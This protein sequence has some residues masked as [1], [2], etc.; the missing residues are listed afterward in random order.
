MQKKEIRTIYRQQRM[1]L[2]L[3]EVARMEDLL[4]IR[5]QQAG[6]PPVSV[7]MGYMAD[8]AR[9]EPDPGNIIRWFSFISPGMLELAPRIH[10]TGCGM[11]AFIFEEGQ[12]VT[13]NA[14]G[15]AE[16]QDTYPVDPL[17]ID[18]VLVP[19]LAFDRQGNRV[20]YGKGYYD[21]FL[22]RCRPDC[23]KVGLSFFGPVDLI[24]D[25]HPGDVRLDLCITPEHIYQWPI[26]S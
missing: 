19:M 18:L 5:I 20:G 12:P 1:N 3:R 16:P 13:L 2:G 7:L 24:S 22:P 11:D 17:A 23:L 10:D 14:F 25:V 6:I 4:L 26:S 15:I 8:P 21:R 9:H